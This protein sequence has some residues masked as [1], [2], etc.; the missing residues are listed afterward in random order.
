IAP[1]KVSADSKDAVNGSQLHAVQESVAGLEGKVYETGAAAAALAG[2]HPIQYDP[3]EPTQVM[4]A[5]G[6]YEGKNSVALGLAHYPKENTLLHIGS[7]V[8]NHAMINGGVTFRFGNKS[9]K[10]AIPDRYKNGPISSVYVMQDEVS[11][12]KAS[13]QLMKERAMQLASENAKMEEENRKLMDEFSR[14]QQQNEETN[15]QLKM[16]MRQMGI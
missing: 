9:A 5:V 6:N 2:L 3:L 7:T 16:L 4:A 12:L 1:G 11:A 14:L 13:T 10:A 15:A 8:N